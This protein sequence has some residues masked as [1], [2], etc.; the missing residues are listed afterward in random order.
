MTTWIAFFRGINVGGNN[1][2]PMKSL[3]VLLQKIGYEN[4]R[5]Y[6]QSGNVVFSS[7]AK[8]ARAIEKKIAGEVGKTYGFEPRVTVLS[9]NDL[10]QAIVANPFPHATDNHKS[11]HLYFLAAPAMHPNLGVLNAVKAENEAFVVAKSVFYLHAPDGIGK[12][13]L[14]ERAEKLLGVSATARNWRTVCKVREM[15]NAS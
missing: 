8:N 7:V 6:I 9:A 1:I 11:L 5:T 2:L 10:G 15:C 4:V 13:K 3:V 14:A 12:S